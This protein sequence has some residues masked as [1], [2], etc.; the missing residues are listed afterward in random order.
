MNIT[1]TKARTGIGTT[2]TIWTA[3]IAIVVVT[4][5]GFLLRHSHFDLSI[6]QSFNAHHH[7][8]VGKLTDAVYKFFG[9]LYAIIGTVLITGIIFIASR[10]IRLTSS[11]ALTIAGTWL[12]AAVVKAA[13]HRLRPD[14]ALLQFPFNPGQIDPS[15]PSGHTAFITTLVV[16]LFLCA[17]IGY[18]RWLVAIIGGLIVI[19]VVTALL[20]DGVHYPSD[21]LASI[22]WSVTVA[23]L[24]WMIW[25]KVFRYQ[26]SR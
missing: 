26:R 25:T 24:V 3:A 10:N 18:R 17:A 21:I 7:G 11:F 9:P 2:R 1:D 12:S 13:V 14:P 22:I 16:T 5:V 20:V 19:G 23:P 4:I 6:V 8:T 15:Y